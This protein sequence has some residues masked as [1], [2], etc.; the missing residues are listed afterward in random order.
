M[1]KIFLVP[2][3]T[4]CLI[5]SGVLSGCTK[6]EEERWTADCSIYLE[7][8][9]EE[10]A[11][12]SDEVKEKIQITV[13][14]VGSASG[15]RF[16]VKLSDENDYQ[17]TISL[18]PG[19]YR[20]SNVYVSDQRLA[21]FQ[22]DTADKTVEVVKDSQSQL[23]VKLTDPA[24]FVETMK[25][26][27]P[28]EEILQAD[29]FSRQVQYAGKIVDLNYIWQHM[30]F[31]TTENKRL[32]P[33]E[34]YY[35]PSTSHSGVSMVVQN[36]TSTMIAINEATFIGVRFFNN[37]VVFPGGITMGMNVPAIAHKT[38]GL[39]GVPDYCLGSPLIGQG[40]S[41]AV[42]VYLDPVSGDRISFTVNSGDPL[43]NMV[44]YEFAKYE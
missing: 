18:T 5:L 43:I 37:N 1:R 32:S 35:I 31:S 3:L 33:S 34:V 40:Y 6:T 13:S 8:L 12:L 27:Q 41:E 7:N 30:Q 9:P 22:V 20:V 17:E 25:A 38:K 36:Q 28:L 10:Y 26:N 44:T 23:P 29:P 11:L 15:K 4:F 42:L 21:M 24:G 16:S 14:L 39:M 2:L 19:T